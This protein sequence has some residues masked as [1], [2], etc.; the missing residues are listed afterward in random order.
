[1]TE[2]V[3]TNCFLVKRNNNVD[4]AE[5]CLAMKKRGFGAGMWNGSGGKPNE[6]ETVEEAAKRE[7]SEELGVELTEMSKRA[8]IVWYLREEDK[9]VRCHV[10]FGEKWENE[11]VETEEMRPR[12]FGVSEIPYDQMWQSDR[13]WLAE[14][15]KG[16]IIKA[17][18]SYTKEGGQVEERELVETE[19]F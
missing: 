17:R 13:E 7:V 10:Y 4:I 19:G 8:E 9:L 3:F 14:V 2:K 15:L 1:M 6:G 5:V 12:W 18:Y 16:R 11:P